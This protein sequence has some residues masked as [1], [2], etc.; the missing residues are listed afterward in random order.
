MFKILVLISVRNL[1]LEFFSSFFILSPRCTAMPEGEIFTEFELAVVA[2]F[3]SSN[4]R[5]VYN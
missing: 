4:R 2:Q 3:S 1:Y 5:I